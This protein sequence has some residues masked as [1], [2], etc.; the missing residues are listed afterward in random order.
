[1]QLLYIDFA[2][3]WFHIMNAYL[4][5]IVKAGCAHAAGTPLFLPDISLAE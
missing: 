2:N 4:R 1:M 5:H 3:E